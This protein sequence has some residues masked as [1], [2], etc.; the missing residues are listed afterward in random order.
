LK[1]ST[2]NAIRLTIATLALYAL[3]ACSSNTGTPA[4]LDTST[5]LSTTPSEATES[6]SVS[7]S[8]SGSA[9]GTQA[10]VGLDTAKVKGVGTVLVNQDGRTV[11]LFTNDTGSTSTC[12][13]SCINTWP[14][15]ISGGEANVSGGADDSKVGTTNAGQVTYDGH[16]LYYYSGDSGAGE[17]NGQG[18]GGIWFAVTPDGNPAGQADDNGGGNGGSG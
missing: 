16:P 13:G 5:S 12:T 9:S 17:A 3:A 2:V 1:G 15:V 11:Y 18:I 4:A 14:A 7:A 6:S 8:S 10:S